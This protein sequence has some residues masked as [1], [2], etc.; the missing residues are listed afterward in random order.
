M[1]VAP[2]PFSIS[3]RWEIESPSVNAMDEGTSI[4]EGPAL[5]PLISDPN[6]LRAEY[7]Q[8]RDPFDYLKVHPADVERKGQEGWQLDR[9][10]TASVWLKKEKVIDRQLVWCLF[11]RMGYASLTNDPVS[12]R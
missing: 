11:Y 12:R 4:Q 9:T 7:R 1:P 8:R 10:L 3:Q 5:S 2:R 6:E